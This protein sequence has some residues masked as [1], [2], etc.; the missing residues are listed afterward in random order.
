MTCRINVREIKIRSSGCKRKIS[1]HFRLIVVF[2]LAFFFVTGPTFSTYHTN[3]STLVKTP[4]SKIVIHSQIKSRLLDPRQKTGHPRIHPRPVLLSTSIPPRYN[5]WQF[6]PSILLADQGTSGV[7][8]AG[9][10][11]SPEVSGAE[12]GVEYLLL[13]PT[14][15]ALLPAGFQG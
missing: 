9:V 5:T 12:H 11:A 2:I 14:V 13:A 6:E 1:N 3:P 8:S 4:W 10:D 7:T 15:D